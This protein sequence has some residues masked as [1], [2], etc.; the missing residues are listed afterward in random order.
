LRINALA[1]AGG[2]DL[3]RK[4]A[5][6]AEN[7]SI[8]PKSKEELN[9]AAKWVTVSNKGKPR[10]KL[11]NYQNGKAIWQNKLDPELRNNL[12]KKVGC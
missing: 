6:L 12:R 11:G 9:K 5:K 1:S 2:K 7:N 3:N 4:A 10:D 8:P